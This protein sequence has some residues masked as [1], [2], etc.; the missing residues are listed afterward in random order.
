MHNFE[1]FTPTKVFFGKDVEQSIG[2]TVQAYGYKKVLVHFGGG[3]VKKIGLLQLIEKQLTAAG[4]AYIELGGVEPNPKIG[5]VREGIAL[6]KKEKV[7]FI[8]AV[9]GGSVIDS[10]K[11][12]SLGLANDRDPW[13]MIIE[14][15]AATRKFPIGVVL[16]LAAAGSEM[17]SSH[18]LT[19]PE[20]NLKRGLNSDMVR[21]VV[22]FM[23]PEHTYTVSKFQTGC[24]TV[25]IMMHTLERY[26]TIEE[27][28]DLTDRI[29]EGLLVAVKAAGLKAM[30]N[31]EDYEA[32]AT[33]MW[34]SSLSHNDLTG[35]GKKKLF[36]V[37]KMEHDVSGL[38]DHVAHGA[39]LSV[40]FPAWAKYVYKHDV[41]KFAQF[42]VRVMGIEMNFEHPEKTALAGIEALKDYFKS[43]DMPTTMAE[44][45]IKPEDFEKIADKTTDCGKHQVLSYTPL[46]KEDLLK[47]Y[48]LA[49]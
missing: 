13:D 19:N 20:G 40:L 12:I 37:H 39:G 3:S 23:N 22:A 30:E 7:D 10:A 11:G 33:L 49:K 15:Y 14:G 26:F 6:C 5:L 34:A 4:I 45:G 8:L 1:Y 36:S 25:D 32:R 21:P 48:A 2:Q 41:R 28:T 35:C 43:L 29:S 18:V 42:A 16:T 17:S 44:L 31:P 24:G 9:G 38:F 46:A 27:D 47:I